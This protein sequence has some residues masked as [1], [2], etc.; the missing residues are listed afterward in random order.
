MISQ[1]QPAKFLLSVTIFC[2]LK[3]KAKGFS[4]PS[5]LNLKH[6][7]ITASKNKIIKNYAFRDKRNL[8]KLH[9]KQ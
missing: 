4:L 1:F 7:F 9:Q 6:G 3:E 2:F 8:T 5:G